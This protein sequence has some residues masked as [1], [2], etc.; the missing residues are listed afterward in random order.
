M[1]LI[2][3]PF[4]RGVF[5]RPETSGVVPENYYPDILNFTIDTEGVL[6][7]RFN[8]EETI[9]LA[10]TLNA[11]TTLSLQSGIEALNPLVLGT[12][13]AALAS[14]IWW[15]PHDS[16]GKK[17]VALNKP[18]GASADV[19]SFGFN[20]T[21][22]CFTEY[23]SIIY[24]STDGSSVRKITALNFGTS[25]ITEAIVASSPT[26]MVGIIA[27]KN[28]LF[29]W[30][31]NRVYFTDVP[32]AGGLPETWNTGAN[33]FDI[34][35]SRGTPVIMNVLPVENR[36]YFFTDSGL[37]SVLISGPA[38]TWIQRSVDESIRVRDKFSCFVHKNIM[39][40]VDDQSVYATDGVN[41]TNIGDPV[42]TLLDDIIVGVKR[43]VR[44]FM[45]NNRL[46]YHVRL[47]DGV[48]ATA[49][50]YT[51]VTNMDDIKWTRLYFSLDGNKVTSEFHGMLNDITTRDFPGTPQSLALISFTN[52][53]ASNRED[54][55]IYRAPKGEANDYDSI[56][57]S[58]EAWGVQFSLPLMDFGDA[59]RYKKLN[60]I[61][62]E[63]ENPL[64]FTGHSDPLVSV[65][66]AQFYADE[67]SYTP[68]TTNI[69][70]TNPGQYSKG[71]VKLIGPS[72]AFRWIRIHVSFTIPLN[73]K[74][75]YLDVDVLG[76]IEPATY[77]T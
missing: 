16:G 49:V 4:D 11:G 43:R 70:F 28:R 42:N 51:F 19:A 56:L 53:S 37:F 26:N 36:L 33:F 54:T 71:M 7:K 47:K 65:A 22:P 35:A 57:G 24:A 29:G 73:V 72:V 2:K 55:R 39:Y 32:S 17:I 8:I 58:A 15:N 14:A 76:E 69:S 63:V 44:L 38:S 25:A 68:P 59:L 66:A 6:R 60:Y 61:L 62:M 45:F 5:Y 23:N 64:R 52:G 12:A 18:G 21:T 1:P 40:F 46:L 77:T 3:I 34:G 20:Y 30:K 75:L 10:N 74:A 27:F 50:T 31:G 9:Y 67:D 41:F 13:P 48:N